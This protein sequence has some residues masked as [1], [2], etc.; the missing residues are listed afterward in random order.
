MK[1]I[2]F[3]NLT[4]GIEAIERFGLTD[5]QFVRI[6]SSICEAKHWERLL[7]QMDDN[8]LMN[9]A[10]GNHCVIYDFS[11][12]KEI[13]RALYQGVAFLEFV[14][15]RRWFNR[16]SPMVI[17]RMINNDTYYE[18][19][20]QKIQRNKL[21]KKKLDYFKKF[22]IAKNLN[23]T[24]KYGHTDLDSRYDEYRKILLNV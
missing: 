14:L 7:E 4:N 11:A 15:E 24:I 12:N 19:A 23:I 5:Y 9:L 22:L 8:L 17:R 3:I 13:P 2:N 10:L 21:I 18:N 16:N 1:T 6:Q 20:Y